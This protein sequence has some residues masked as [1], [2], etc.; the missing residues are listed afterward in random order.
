MG[1]CRGYE[2]ATKGSEWMTEKVL[3]E[4]KGRAGTQSTEAEANQE[5]GATSKDIRSGVAGF[6]CHM[7]CAD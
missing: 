1:S 4:G 5:N 2:Y 3:P 6:R 7:G